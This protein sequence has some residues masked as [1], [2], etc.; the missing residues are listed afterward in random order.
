VER[1]ISDRH[2]P[3]AA[4]IVIDNWDPSNLILF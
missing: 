1:E 3:A 2:D 4:T